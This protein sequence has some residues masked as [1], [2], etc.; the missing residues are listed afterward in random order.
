MCFKMMLRSR[1]FAEAIARANKRDRELGVDVLQSI[2]SL[3]QHPQG[4]GW[5]WRVNYGLK[6]YVGGRGRD[7]IVE[8]NPEDV[9]IQRI[10]WEQ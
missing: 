2:I 4:E 8:V 1:L 9:S 5:V 3:T 6:D 7:L 10:L